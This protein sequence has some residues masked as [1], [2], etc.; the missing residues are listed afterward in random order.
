MIIAITILALFVVAVVLVLNFYPHLGGKPSPEQKQRLVQSKNFRNGKFI[1]QIPT[2][3]DSSVKTSLSILR[4]FVKPNP[5]RKPGSP[6]PMEPLHLPEDQDAKVTWFG[7]SA[8]LLQ[9][10]GKTL[11]V[12]PMFGRTPSPFPQVGGGRYSGQLPFEIEELP[13]IDAVI[14]SHD[15]YDHL[16]YGSIKSLK[17]KVRTFFVPLGVGA[18]LKRWGVA[19]E[20]IQEHDW[21]SEFQYEGLTLACTPARHFSGRSLTDRDTTL[22]CSW[23]IIGGQTRLYFSGDGGYGPHFQEIGRAYGPFD[24]TFMECG[25]YDPRWAAIH[26]MPEET[27]Q[28]HLDVQ[29]KVL[30]PI[31]WAAFTLALHDWTDPVERVLQAAQLNNVT[32]AT[33]KLGEAVRVHAAE[34]PVSTWWR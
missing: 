12:D 18:H 24:L 4:D 8:L 2:R 5:N 7:H 30:I 15:H 29:G 13:V 28:A 22:W 16:D 20:K 23:V 33:P 17:D 9:L 31:H 19:A 21:W 14:L 25:Q 1:N 11:L 34:Y 10:D 3:M 32:L 26:M 6:L 27:V